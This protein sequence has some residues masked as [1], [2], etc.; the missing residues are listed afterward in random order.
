MS[1]K[2]CALWEWLAT[3][4]PCSLPLH[5]SSQAGMP[6]VL[7]YLNALAFSRDLLPCLCRWLALGVGLPLEGP[8]AGNT[9]LE[10]C[11]TGPRHWR[12]VGAECC[13][14]GHL[15]LVGLQC[16]TCTLLTCRSMSASRR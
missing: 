3:A 11:C 4:L 10:H 5:V 1:T 13:R 12:P 7:R 15:L 2:S 8:L 6:L 14:P 9:R 16:C